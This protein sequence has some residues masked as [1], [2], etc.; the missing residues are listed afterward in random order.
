MNGGLRECGR[1]QDLD[2]IPILFR[3][4]ADLAGVQVKEVPLGISW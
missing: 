1:F 4:L 3:H 2:L